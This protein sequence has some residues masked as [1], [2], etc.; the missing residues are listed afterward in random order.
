MAVR[1]SA[2]LYGPGRF[3]ELI[4]VVRGWV[5]PTAIVRLEGLG[6]FKKSTSAGLEPPIFRLV[7]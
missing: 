4:P 6:Q 3:P 7:E 1:L 5:D 2:A